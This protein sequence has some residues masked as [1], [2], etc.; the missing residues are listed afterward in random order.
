[1]KLAK[2]L[3]AIG[4]LHKGRTAFRQLFVCADHEIAAVTQYRPKAADQVALPIGVK[5]GEGEIAA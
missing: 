5:I 2:D 4:N 1:M 3:P